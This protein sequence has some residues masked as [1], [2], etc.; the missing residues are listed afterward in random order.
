[1]W[2]AKMKYRKSP[3]KKILHKWDKVLTAVADFMVSYAWYNQSTQVYDLG[4]RKHPT[5]PK[6]DICYC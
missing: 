2:F 4:P 6:C 3:T 5:A 1:M